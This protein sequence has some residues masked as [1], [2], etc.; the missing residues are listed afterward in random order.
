MTIVIMKKQGEQVLFLRITVPVHLFPVRPRE[1]QR[2]LST[3]VV[4]YN[5]DASTTMSPGLRAQSDE[6]A[7][8]SAPM[9]FRTS[10]VLLSMEYLAEGA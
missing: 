2:W 10:T 1:K 6:Q 9:P 8:R 5:S 7:M 4:R 3:Y